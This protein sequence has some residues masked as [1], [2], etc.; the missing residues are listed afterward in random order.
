MSHNLLLNNF[1]YHQIEVY[2]FLCVDFSFSTVSEIRKAS[3]THTLGSS[4]PWP[5]PSW[6]LLPSCPPSN[7]S[8]IPNLIGQVTKIISRIVVV[9]KTASYLIFYR[10]VV[11]EKL[12]D[13]LVGH[14]PPCVVHHVSSLILQQC[15]GMLRVSDLQDL[16]LSVG[17]YHIAL[18]TVL[19]FFPLSLVSWHLLLLMT[20]IHMP[21]FSECICLL[22]G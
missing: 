15:I 9:G 13:M 2:I 5:K 21:R 11:R 4:L 20:N 8:F 18:C 3:I 19:P 12:Q 6:L 16:L 22:H 17:P 14:S 10:S 7:P 1:I